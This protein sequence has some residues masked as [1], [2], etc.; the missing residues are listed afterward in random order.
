MIKTLLKEIKEVTD[1]ENP[2]S[3]IEL[4]GIVKMSTQPELMP[5]F[6]ESLARCM[7]KDIG[8][9]PQVQIESVVFMLSDQNNVEKEK[10]N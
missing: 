6:K 10:Q 9:S 5:V 8:N 1:E 7:F 2:S 3:Q 4:V